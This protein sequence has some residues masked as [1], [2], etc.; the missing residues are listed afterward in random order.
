MGVR[1]LIEN[2]SRE[3]RGTNNEV[4]RK[5]NVGDLFVVL[6]QLGFLFLVGYGFYVLLFP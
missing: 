4:E 1:I 3:S 6:I 5:G 2:P